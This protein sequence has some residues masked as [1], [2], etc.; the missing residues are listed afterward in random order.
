MALG[1]TRIF[2]GLLVVALG[3]AY[4]VAVAPHP[5]FAPPQSAQGL[6]DQ[7]DVLAWNNRW[8]EAKPLYIRSAAMFRAEHQLSKAL[9]A[10][11]SEVPAEQLGSIPATIAALTR[12][13]SL[14]ESQDAPLT[15][16]RI[17]TVRGM[18]EINYNAG[19]A[20]ATWHE[21]ENLALSQGQIRLASRAE[22]E[23]G[24][25]AFILGDTST[26]K[27][28]VVHA[29]ALSLA[30]RDPAATVRYASTFGAGLVQLLRYQEALSPLEEAIS[31]AR[32]NPQVGPPFIARYAKIDALAGLHREHEALLQADD[33]LKDLRDT[34]YDTHK[35]QVF[36]SRGS[37]H[38]TEG[39]LLLATGDNQEA[40]KLSEKIGFSRGVVSSATA[41]AEVLEDED[42]LQDANRSIDEAL[43]ASRQAP[44]EVY[45]MPQ[46][47][48]VKADILRRLGQLSAADGFYRR[49]MALV[50]LMLQHAQTGEIQRRLLSEMSNVYSGYF[51]SLCGQRRYNEALK[52]LDNIRG[53]IE[54]EAL[55][56]RTKTPPD[57]AT[58]EAELTRLNLFL[59]NTDD[60]ATR[61]EINSAIYNAE[62]F[63]GGS[64]IDIARESIVHPVTLP[65]LQKSLRPST[66]LVEY[67]LAE[68][69]SYMLAITRNGAKHY[70]LPSKTEIEADALAY[71]DN[72]RLKK[73]DKGLARKLFNELL[74][75][76][77]EYGSKTDLILVPDGSLHLLPFSALMDGSGYLLR[78]H[79]V[80][81]S[82][83]ATV[84]T[85]LQNRDR[86][87]ISS[88]S[89]YLGVAAWTQPTNTRNFLTR[90]LSAPVQSDFTALPASKH[91]VEGIAQDFP[92]PRTLLEGADAT[93]TQFK[94]LPLVSTDVIH[95]ALHGYVDLDYP[96]RS[97]LVFA[98]DP[99]QKEDGLL[100]IREIRSLHLHAR[101]VTLSACNTGVG[102]V[103]EPGV[104]NLVNAFIGA[105]AHS[106]VS[107]LWEL[108]DQPTSRL[109]TDF[110][111]GLSTHARKVEALRAAQLQLL[112]RGLVPYYWAGVQL[113]GDANGT[114]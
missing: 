31:I 4:A 83:S 82:P 105:G 30:E 50:D 41:L 80:A 64:Q 66:L 29:W 71:R 34:P 110:Y 69:F 93:E 3:L 48:A 11:V 1:S 47:L 91:E 59:L 26:A 88:S 37:L 74:Q 42:R 60:P 23:Q 58:R 2:L 100:Q 72:L 24:I 52:I 102:P 68:P 114:F 113:V 44:D 106:V 112:D 38:R 16:L 51:V 45:L 90:A 56:H 39:Q 57:M 55:V 85:L 78:T 96:D 111:E 89:A 12:K 10:E 32:K 7:A 107:T 101:L 61:A 36:L 13:L 84:F 43:Y 103:G 54:A 18:L 20:R 109:M 94:R 65:A 33:L 5:S 19:Q 70:Q 15:K 62:T 104:A 9:Y 35:V 92:N 21:V 46:V 53:R 40:L 76:I 75:P 73:E 81:I 67:V 86:T 98:P 108:T 17:L 49:G 6:L 77:P 25:A 97:A 63:E 28:K 8:P 14:P 99:T 95:L 22:G 87:R 27:A 79:T